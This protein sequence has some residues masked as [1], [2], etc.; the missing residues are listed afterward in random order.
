[1]ILT[2][3]LY[4]AADGKTVVKTGD[5][6]AAFLLGVPGQSIPDARAK[7]LGLIQPPQPT[8][9]VNPDPEIQTRDPEVGVKKR[10]KRSG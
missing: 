2:E 5:P 8:V 3:T 4:F 10:G 1:M 6:R 7:A 9:A